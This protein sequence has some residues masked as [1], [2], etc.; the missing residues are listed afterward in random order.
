MQAP[1]FAPSP[2]DDAKGHN[3]SEEMKILRCGRAACFAQTLYDAQREVGCAAA[4]MKV[5]RSL[6]EVVT[7]LVA[8][9]LECIAIAEMGFMIHF[10]ELL[11][12]SFI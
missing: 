2:K 3:V 10:V 12:S 8:P 6:R 4:R 9:S 11:P 7:P 5:T 1:S